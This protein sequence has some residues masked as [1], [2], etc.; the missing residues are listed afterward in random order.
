M[1]CDVTVTV[2]LYTVLCNAEY[3]KTTIVIYEGCSHPSR[4]IYAP[5]QHLV[6][7]SLKLGIGL[8][9]KESVV[10]ILNKNIELYVEV[11]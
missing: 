8:K 9:I 7:Q 1:R 3:S 5:L 6:C 2:F 10:P 4:R 11:F